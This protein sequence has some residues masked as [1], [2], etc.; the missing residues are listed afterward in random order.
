MPPYPFR[1]PTKHASKLELGRHRFF[2]R[3]VDRVS[4]DLG[5]QLGAML[6]PETRPRRLQDGSQDEVRDIFRSSADFGGFL[7]DAR[8]IWA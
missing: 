8:L 7:V 3:D 4:L 1:K 5:R 2:D 6:A